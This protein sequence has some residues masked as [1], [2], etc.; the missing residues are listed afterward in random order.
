MGLFSFFKKPDENSPAREELEKAIEHFDQGAYQEAL[1]SLGSGLKKDVAYI[2]LYELAAACLEKLGADEEKALFEAAIHHTNDPDTFNNLGDF[3][4]SARH[5]D[6]AQVFYEK[7][8]QLQPTHDTAR[9]DLAICFARQFQLDK[10][11][12]L[13][14]ENTSGNFWDL[15]FLNKCKILTNETAGVQASITQLQQFLA[16]QPNQ[17]EM[18]IPARKVTE[19]QESLARLQSMP[20]IR[21][22]IRDWHFVQYGGVILDYFETEEGEDYVAGGRYV[23]SWGSVESIKSVV[24]K[25]KQFAEKLSLSFAGI[26]ALPNRDTE[27]LGRLLAKEFDVAYYTY[28][29]TNAYQDCLIVTSDSAHL[30]HH[31]TLNT[32]QN[33]QIVFAMN[34]SWLDAAVV[35]PD[36]IGFMTQLYSFPWDGGGMRVGE[37]GEVEHL[38]EDTREAAVIAEEI[39]RLESPAEAIPDVLD[40]YAAH[41]ELLKGIGAHGKGHRY[42]FMIESPVPGSHFS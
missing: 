33:G 12:A 14:K 24:V 5:Y 13:L 30:E 25:L 11:L 19:L 2:P 34:H 9:H 31:E 26:V 23:A 36:I 38:P 8:L 32:I 21:T 27:I 37:N 6:K 29:A 17:E 4:F 20:V 3:F 39:F 15:Y 22:H 40:F 28:D 35:C 41:R 42:N 16:A 7:T 1:R 10:A 18:E